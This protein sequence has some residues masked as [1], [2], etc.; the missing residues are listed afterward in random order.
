MAL[1][2]MPNLLITNEL[3]ETE[4]MSYMPISSPNDK[5]VALNQ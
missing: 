1:K 3:L 4:S 2:P 5:P